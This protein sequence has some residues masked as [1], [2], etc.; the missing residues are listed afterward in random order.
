MIKKAMLK[1]QTVTRKRVE[2]NR[3]PFFRD[4]F[5]FVTSVSFKVSILIIGM[6]SVSLMFIYLYRYMINSPYVKL[7]F[8]QISG[9]D[10]GIKRE[11]IKMAGLNEGMSL[12]T[13]NPNDIKAKM[14]KH[15]WIRSV[16]LEKRFPHT[17]IVKAEKESPRAMV[18]FDKMFYM[19]RWGKVFKE[20]DKDDD[21]DYPVITGVSKT[22]DNAEEK[23]ALAAGIL[24]S[25]ESETGLLS[26]S[27]ISEIHVNTGGDAMIYSISMPVAIRMSGGNLEEGKNRIKRLVRYL[28]NS[29][30]IDTVR[31]IDMNY[32]DG[33]VVSFKKQESLAE[34]EKDEN[35]T[36]GL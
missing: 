10:D 23:L 13:I 16:E 7:K 17:L 5:R 35:L 29:N 28:Q 2:S 31:V 32:L 14:E 24:D 27:D 36:V 19:N 21:V 30:V 18:L 15:P 3:R 4:V 33:A 6:I 25:F 11:M 34:S 22:D 12:L 20:L 26:L 8:I 1:N 9:V